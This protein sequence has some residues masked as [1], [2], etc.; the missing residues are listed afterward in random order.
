MFSMDN[1]KSY[2]YKIT[3]KITDVKIQSLVNVSI[4]IN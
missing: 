3:C 1:K 2:V 4:M